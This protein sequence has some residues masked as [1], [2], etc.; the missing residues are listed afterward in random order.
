MGAERT[1]IPR[2]GRPCAPRAPFECL[3]DLSAERRRRWINPS[4]AGSGLCSCPTASRRPALRVSPPPPRRLAWCAPTRSRCRRRS[5]GGS[6]QARARRMRPRRS[7]HFSQPRARAGASRA[8]S[9]RRVP[10]RRRRPPRL[11][12]APTVRHL[13]RPAAGTGRTAR[14]V[15]ARARPPRRQYRSPVALPHPSAEPRREVWAFSCLDRRLN[16]FQRCRQLR[17]RRSRSSECQG[18]HLRRQSSHLRRKRAPWSLRRCG[19]RLRRNL[20]LLN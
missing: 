5:V 4:R 14:P 7:R 17:H 1:G 18:Y 2:G 15:A 10:P 6:R 13:Q 9:L 12:R 16:V 8:C 3:S 20:R 11:C 19:R